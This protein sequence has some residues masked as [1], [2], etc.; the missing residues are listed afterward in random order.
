MA[1]IVIIEHRMQRDIGVPYL[2]HALA[3]SWRKAGH[4]VLMQYGPQ[5]AP[6]GDLAIL[7]LDLTVVPAGYLPLLGR[8]PR[9]IN[10][11]VSDVSKTRFSQNLI[12]RTSNWDGPVIV[13]TATNAGG[14]PERALHLRAKEAGVASDIADTP[15][16]SGYVLYP[17]PAAVPEAMWAMRGLVVER[18]LPEQEGADYFLRNWTFLGDR[19]RNMR[20]RSR[21][22][23]VKADSFLDGE[24]VPV[25]PELR[26]WRARLGFD[27]GRFDYVRHGDQWVLL[28]ANRT[29]TLPDKAGAG[30]LAMIDHFSSA[31]GRYL[32]R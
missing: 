13:K 30:M 19:E 14:R 11:A 1:T 4:T 25:P 7:H 6:A 28:D 5:D 26:A 20:W 8:Y 23:I 24:Q 29:P 21:E 27:F 16:M 22:P 17:S 3:E 32:P 18:F 15:V 10:G 12:D 2:V 9:V 31:I